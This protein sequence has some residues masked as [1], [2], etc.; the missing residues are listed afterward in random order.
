MK[1]VLW[2]VVFYCQVASAQRLRKSDKA[3][4]ENLRSEIG[5]LASDRLEGRRTG[6][7]GE[8]LAYEYLADQFKTIG[9]LPK[10]DNNT[11]LQAFEINE[12]KEVLPKTR[13]NING[14]DLLIHEDFFPFIFSAQGSLESN[15]SPAFLEKGLPWFW[16]IKDVI[17]KNKDNPHFDLENAIQNKATEFAQKG[18]SAVIVYNNGETDDELKFEDKEKI[19]AQNIPVIF[20]KKNAAQKILNDPS[21]NLEIKLTIAIGD[22]IRHGHNIV[23]YIDNGAANTIIIGAHYDHLGYGEDHNSLWAGE[24]EIHNGAD[25]NASGTASVIELARMLKES[26]LKNN[27]YLFLCF[28]GEELGLYG[29]KYFTEHPTVNLD[30]VN[31]MINSDMIGR[32][33]DSS[34]S[35]TIGGYGTSPSWGKVFDN[36]EKYFTIHFDSSGIGPSDHTS[37][38]LKNIPVLFFFTGT[39]KDYHKPTDDVEKIN[40]TGELMVIK[41]IYDIL[42]ETNREG[43]L[44]FSKTKEP[45]MGGSRFTV[46]LGIMPDYTFSGTG[47]RA[48][49]IIDGKIAQKVGMQVGDV[50]IKLGDHK[51]SDLNSYMKALGGFKKGDA[52][53]VTVLRGGNELTFDI[54]F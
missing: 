2:L 1:N 44:A 7:P 25:D 52:T 4:I 26:K 8:K 33:N 40:F 30:G 5:Y 19:A 15:A 13:L 36:K 21:A 27:N 54:V 11:F 37:F 31:Y 42:E 3:I 39:H 14:V 49:G 50:I 29:S 9:L 17:E 35:L 53:K 18:A 20:I 12:G 47:V 48:D 23:G 6:T 32:L 24:R 45:T 51:S 10:G 34:H 22:K 41:Y 43:K 28:S 38:Y 16:D 46:S